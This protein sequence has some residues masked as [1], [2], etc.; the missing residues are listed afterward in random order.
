MM[1]ERSG[2]RLQMRVCCW[3]SG[4]SG[5]MTCVCISSV[6]IQ[7]SCRWLRVWYEGE[8]DQ[9]KRVKVR[10]VSGST[11]RA[12]HERLT[13]AKHKDKEASSLLYP[14]LLVM[15][16]GTRPALRFRAYGEQVLRFLGSDADSMLCSVRCGRWV[17]PVVHDGA[18]LGP[19]VAEGQE[20]RSK[21]RARGSR[22]SNRDKA[23]GV[24]GRGA[25][26]KAISQCA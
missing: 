2:R 12:E 20:G 19:E 15:A 9:I 13:R 11:A 18:S 6:S 1:K 16:P 4:M 7:S 26:S 14:L 17:C 5:L 23:R 21:G 8:T 24:E 22:S 25:N 10:G 3:L